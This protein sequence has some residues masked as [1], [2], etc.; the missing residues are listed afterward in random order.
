M[1]A[2][3][4]DAVSLRPAMPAD[5]TFLRAVYASTRAG[6][7]AL[8]AWDDT[9]KAAFVEQQFSAQDQHYRTHYEG[10]TFD[11]IEIGG[12]PAGRLYVHVGERDIRIVDIALLP[13][14]RGQG[15]GGALIGA[16]KDRAQA[17]GRVL[18]I[19]VEHANPARRLYERLGFVPVTDTGLHL[20]MQ[21]QPKTASYSVPVAS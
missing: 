12:R 4:T 8:V 3:V 9:A 21:V 11:V 15:A 17:T 6:E 7:L 1:S 20:L 18:S 16:L 5:R 13:E 2:T 14:F 19:H 10:A